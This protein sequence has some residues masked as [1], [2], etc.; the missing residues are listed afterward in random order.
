MGCGAKWKQIEELDRALGALRGTGL[1]PGT[2][3]YD[4]LWKLR[5]KVFGQL[6]IK[7]PRTVTQL[8]KIAGLSPGTITLWHDIEEGW[9][10]EARV[11]PGAPPVYKSVSDEV[12]MA[13]LKREITKELE[14]KLMTPDEYLGE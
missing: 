4:T 12:A 1:G 6:G 3:P 7:F 8:I 9:M 2:T 13:I 10:S 5:G 11:R 14:E